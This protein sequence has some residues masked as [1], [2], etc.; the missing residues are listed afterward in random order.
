MLAEEVVLEE[1]GRCGCLP[2]AF[3]F[4]EA[5]TLPCAG[6]TAWVGLVVNGGLRAGEAVLAMGTG[7]PSVFALQIAKLWRAR[8]ILTARRDEKLARGRTLGADATTNYRS[9][10]GWDA[11]A[12]ALTGGQGVDHVLEAV[13]G[14][15]Q[16]RSLRALRDGGHLS[17]VGLLGG[18]RGGLAQWPRD[19]R[20]LGLT[21]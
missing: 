3:S 9:E 19:P 10:P 20:R 5:A 15:T 11:R 17:V 21:G 8:A 1:A 12:R 13:G 2:P 16:L 18:S 4:E 14:A 6:V 7:G